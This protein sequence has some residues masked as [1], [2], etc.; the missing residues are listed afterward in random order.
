MEIE[1]NTQF[2]EN[3]NNLLSTIVLPR[4]LG[5]ISDRLPKPQYKSLSRSKSLAIETETKSEEKVKP[6]SSLTKSDHKQ[7][8]LLKLINNQRD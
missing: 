7:A 3:H 2:N 4:N 1:Q 8:S 5:Q 6:V